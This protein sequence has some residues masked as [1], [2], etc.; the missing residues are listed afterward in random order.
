[1]TIN[2]KDLDPRAGQVSRLLGY[3]PAI[4]QDPP[5]GSSE[6]ASPLPL[7]RLLMAFESIF[8]GLPKS[9]PVEWADVN[10]QPGFEEILGGAFEQGTSKTILDGVQRYFD[11]GPDYSV[12]EQNVAN[13]NRAPPEFLAWLAGWVALALREDWT[14][15][16]KRKFIAN[17]VVLYRL[18]GT[19]DGVEQFV[20]AYTGGPV[21]ISEQVAELQIGVH[22]RIG[23]DTILSGGAPFFFRVKLTSS[24][25]VGFEKQKDMVSALIDLQKPAHTSYS[26]QVEIAQFQI[27]VHSTI[28]VDTLLGLSQS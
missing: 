24:D 23:V 18:R 28:G 22:S 16:H 7:G 25:P 4:F 14:E 10:Q 20:H 2:P 13:Y 27:G 11:P 9:S 8:L 3:L 1:M 19:K 5:Q 17:A 12:N 6:A 21:E 15:D 26:L